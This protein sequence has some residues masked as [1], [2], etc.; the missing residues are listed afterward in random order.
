M[1]FYVRYLL[2]P[3]TL[4]A[5]AGVMALLSRWLVGPLGDHAHAVA[6]FGAVAVAGTWIGV[7]ERLCPG[8]RARARR[9]RSQRR[10]DLHY[11]LLTVGGLILW[12][13]VLCWISAWR[14]P[15]ATWPVAL[16]AALA[17]LSGELLTFLVH[18]AS[19]RSGV[20]WLWRMHAVHH[21]P[22]LLSLLSSVRVSAPELAYQCLSLAPAAA[23][24]VTAEPLTWVLAYQLVVGAFQHAD[25]DLRMGALNWVLPGPE[26]HRIH[27]HIDPAKA[28]NFAL[29]LPALD[30]LFRTEGANH[31]PGEVPMGVAGEPD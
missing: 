29:N 6:M 13:L 21:R 28:R 26:M 10:G 3:T 8:E 14:G 9:S 17:F 23:L 5:S 2:V 25:L 12:T 19:H 11:L 22:P 30:L 18:W 24:G 31:G 16:Q 27:H 7:W 4:A 1:L 20:R 15:A